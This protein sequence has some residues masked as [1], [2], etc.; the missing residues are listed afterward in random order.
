MSILSL[1]QLASS[2]LISV[3]ALG[4]SV[5]LR[6]QALI[7]AKQI[8]EIA[9]IQITSMSQAIYSQESQPVQPAPQ[10]STPAQPQ[11]SAPIVTQS[12][13][14]QEPVLGS[15]ETISNPSFSVTITTE[16]NQQGSRRNGKLEEVKMPFT[17]SAEEPEIGVHYTSLIILVIVQYR[18]DL[19]AR[20]VIK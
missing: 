6:Q 12:Q 5:E 4:V 20:S 19:V 11:S 15:A 2:L 3:Q 17:N 14:S 13:P 18:T 7:T 1:L 16:I 9:S 10:S 8:V